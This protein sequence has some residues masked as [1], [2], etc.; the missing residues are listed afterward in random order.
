MHKEAPPLDRSH[1]L[2]LGALALV[3]AIQLV[4][5]CLLALLPALLQLVSAR[6]Q[7]LLAL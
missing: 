2:P 7:R 6:K 4:S 3:R 5:Q 1:A